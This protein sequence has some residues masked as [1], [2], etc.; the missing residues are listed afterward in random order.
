M[1]LNWSQEAH[2]VWD[3]D[4]RRIIGG[5]PSGALDIGYP[6]GA[7]LPGDWFAA[8]EGDRV[9]GYGWM[10]ST[11]GGDTE[12][13]LAVDPAEQGRGVGS[14]IL[15]R[16]EREAAARG[17]N[18]VYNTV[19]PGHPHRDTVHDWLLVRGYRGNEQDASLRKRVE[20]ALEEPSPAGAGVGRA[21]PSVAQVDQEQ[22][23]VFPPGHEESGGYVNIEDHRY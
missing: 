3:E 22:L 8:S 11:W 4:K 14:F 21:A 20:V 2:P 13:L 1:S 16:L 23:T 12:I 15:E 5:A 18:Y 9:L 7:E 17:F 10:D 6:P 19:R